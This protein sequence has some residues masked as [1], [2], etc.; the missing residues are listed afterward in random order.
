MTEDTNAIAEA[1][2]ELRALS[3]DEVDAVDSRRPSRS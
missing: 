3:D 2:A 1:G